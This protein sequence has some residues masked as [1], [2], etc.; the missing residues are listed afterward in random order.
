[1]EPGLIELECKEAVLEAREVG[2][3]KVEKVEEPSLSSSVFLP[4]IGFGDTECGDG[5][6][7]LNVIKVVGDLDVG[8]STEKAGE[9]D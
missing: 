2:A 1:L 5:G 8:N 4:V 7:V 6:L 9:S 3:K